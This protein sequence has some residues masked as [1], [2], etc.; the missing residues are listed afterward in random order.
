MSNVLVMFTALTNPL[1][2]QSA[3]TLSPERALEPVDLNWL[4]DSL[5]TL[6]MGGDWTHLCSG[7]F[8]KAA[9]EILLNGDHVNIV[10]IGAHV[11]FEENDP[12]AKGISILL[13]RLTNITTNSSSELRKHVHWT[14]VEP[15][16]PNFKRLSENMLTHS[17]ICDMKGINAAV[18]SD[19][20]KTIPDKMV[21]YSIRD[22][23]DPE[24]GFDSLS[25]Q[26]LPFYITQLS[27]F[28][29]RPILFNKGAF[30]SRGL[31]VFDYVVK[32]NVTA[33]AFSNL[34][35]EAVVVTENTQEKSQQSA[36]LM[37]L[38]DTEGFDC[39]IVEGI[40]ASSPHLPKYLV[41][42]H[43]QCN[44]KAAFQHLRS[45][46]YNIHTTIE[47]AVAFMTVIEE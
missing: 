21:F 14:F 1:D 17:D 25:N 31:N 36:P 45:M 27:S 47:N 22:T 30:K 26:T 9:A 39:D 12:I 43:K 10:Q 2:L 24:T 20:S 16:P 33:K 19:N 5:C 37:V 44:K 46:G 11:G 7:N 15:S 13:D 41:F 29:M 34:M 40:A 35:K 18:V 6:E 42:E 8:V 28:S 38:I 32:T 3:F 4:H 23:I